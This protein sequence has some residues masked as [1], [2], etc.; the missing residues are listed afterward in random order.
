[1]QFNN[2]NCASP[3]THFDMYIHAF[4]SISKL[5]LFRLHSW[6]G[7]HTMQ[8]WIRSKKLSLAVTQILCVPQ[9]KKLQQYGIS[10]R[11]IMLCGVYSSDEHVPTWSCQFPSAHHTDRC[12][13]RNSSTTFLSGRLISVFSLAAMPLVQ[14]VVAIG[15]NFPGYNEHPGVQLICLL[16]LGELSTAARPTCQTG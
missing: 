6:S 15:H 1:M 8:F 12:E 7:M 9:W 10:F 4:K 13:D 14:Y 2:S 11:D 3:V 5:K 16:W